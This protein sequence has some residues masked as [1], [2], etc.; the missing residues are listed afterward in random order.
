MAS[1]RDQVA[2]VF[3][4]RLRVGMKLQTDPTVIYGMGARYN[5]KLSRADLDTPTEYNTYVISGM[6]PG[7]IAIPAEASLKASGASGEDAV[8]LFCGRRQRAGTRLTPISPAIT[9]QCRN[10]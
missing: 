7:P 10:I 6:P 1:E 4:N 5:G 9:G 2:S 3:I 8:S